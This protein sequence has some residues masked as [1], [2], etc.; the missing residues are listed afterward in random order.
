[1]MI[2]ICFE[3]VKYQQQQK[4]IKGTNKMIVPFLFYIFFNGAKRGNSYDKR[5]PP[6]NDVIR[7]YR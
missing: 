6:S 4:K 7:R 3:K 1:M 5:L 2:V